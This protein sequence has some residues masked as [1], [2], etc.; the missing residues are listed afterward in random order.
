VWSAKSIRIGSAEALE[1]SSLI[2]QEIF[3]VF[4]AGHGQ[5]LSSIQRIISQIDIPKKICL[6]QCL[7]GLI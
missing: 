4:C 3:Q 2:V 1:A 6:S 7:L 5:S